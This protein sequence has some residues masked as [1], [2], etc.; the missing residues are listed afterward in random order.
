MSDMTLRKEDDEWWFFWRGTRQFR[1]PERPN[2]QILK[3]MQWAF[4]CGLSEGKYLGREE[5]LKAVR[6]LLDDVI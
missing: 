5:A 3:Q 6:E 2:D 4:E 1:M